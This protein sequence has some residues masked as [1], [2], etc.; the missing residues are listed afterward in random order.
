M[1]RGLQILGIGLLALLLVA[2]ASIRAAAPQGEEGFKADQKHADGG[3]KQNDEVE[4][5]LFGKAVDLGI[6]TVLVFVILLFVLSKYAW[7]PMMQG[8][9]H[10]ERAIHAALL[11]AQQAR[12]EASRLRGQL[13]EQ[14]RKANDQA[15]QILDEARRA[16][17]R[18][19]AEMTAEAHKKIQGEHERLQREMNLAYE[20]ARRDLQSQAAQLATLVA[21]KV[22]RRQMNHDDH[23]QLVEEALAEL[24]Q[25]GNGRPETARV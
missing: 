16:A 17:E 10:R 7:K 1:Q 8:L 13:E 22:I 3:H 21:G 12:E 20:Q 11:E 25:I 19:T 15:R 14:M 2:P 23:R 5:D 24:R 9:E 18:T 4:Q 6:W